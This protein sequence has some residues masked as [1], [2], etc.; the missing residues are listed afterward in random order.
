MVVLDVQTGEV[1]A[2]A[3]YPSYDP[4]D[5]KNLS[6]AQ[7]RNRALTD[8]FE[9]GSTMKPFVVALGAGDRPRH[10]DDDDPD[11]ARQHHASPARTI[12]RRA[13]AR[14]ADAWPR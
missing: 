7:L 8:T 10:A 3:N 5:R 2:L 11:R 14:R 13:P 9:P 12:T 1:L 4:G 6:G